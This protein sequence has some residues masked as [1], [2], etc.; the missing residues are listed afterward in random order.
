MSSRGLNGPGGSF[1]CL[2]DVT[3]NDPGQGRVLVS[4]ALGTGEATVVWMGGSGGGGLSDGF[5]G[6]ESP[7]DAS[8]RAVANAARAS[9]RAAKTLRQYCVA[10]VIT[11]MWTLTYAAAEWDRGAVTADVNDFLQRLRVHLGGDFPAIYVIEKHPG[12]HGLHVHVGL[13]SGFIDWGLFGSLWGHGHVQYSDGQKGISRVRGKRAQARQLAKY[14]S[15]YMAKGFDECHDFGRHRY[16][17]TQGF[18]V[19]VSR[20]VF[21]TFAGAL[22]WLLDV[23]GSA[24]SV[25][26]C[27]SGVEDWHGPPAWWFQFDLFD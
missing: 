26:W 9:M 21:G 25:S 5:A 13:Q 3:G 24:P 7:E 8:R 1:P 19:I 27:S 22:R 23:E 15:K 10:N 6:A 2:E 11:R 4:R 16:E 18:S 20:R 12:G 14:L 17:V